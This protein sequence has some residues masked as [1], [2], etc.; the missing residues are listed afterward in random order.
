VLCL[1]EGMQIFVKTLTGK[2]TSPWRNGC[3]YEKSPPRT[4]SLRLDD[5]SLPPTSAWTQIHSSGE[6]T[7]ACGEANLHVI[8]ARQVAAMQTTCPGR[9]LKCEPD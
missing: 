3:T 8:R 5:K 2:A 6:A 7:S 1:R 9:S 4:T